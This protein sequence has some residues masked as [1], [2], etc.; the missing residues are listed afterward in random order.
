MRILFEALLSVLI[1]CSAQISAQENEPYYARQWSIALSQESI[2]GRYSI[3]TFIPTLYLL[4]IQDRNDLKKIG[5]QEYIAATTQDDVDVLVLNETVSGRPFRESVGKHQVIFNC[6][7]DLCRARG[8][9][10][11]I[12]NRCGRSER[13]KRSSL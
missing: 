7:Y 3:T 1:I 11:M 4:I 9:T 12:W 2:G 5:S 10:G 8:A 6:P 13:G